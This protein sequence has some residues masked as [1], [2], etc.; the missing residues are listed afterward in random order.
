MANISDRIIFS[1]MPVCQNRITE[2][3]LIRTPYIAASANRNGMVRSGSSF[4]MHNIIISVFFIQMRSFRPNHIFHSSV[5]HIFRFSHK[6]HPL[7]IQLLNPYM[8]ISVITASL[9][10]WMR[11]DII[12]YTVLIKK[13]TWV[14]P[15]CSFDKIRL[16]PWSCWIIRRYD[17]VSSTGYIGADNIEHS[18]MVSD[19]RSK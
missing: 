3:V 6:L 1:K 16:R 5:P 14:N 8:P 11:S 7:Y 15:I 19:G 10:I 2:V 4:G 13:Q 9:G 17:K 18:I 12:A